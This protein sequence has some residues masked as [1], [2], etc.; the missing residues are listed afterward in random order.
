VTG[1]RRGQVR[2]AELGAGGQ[3][4]VLV[5]QTDALHT[6]PTVIVLPLVDTPQRVGFPLALYLP[7]AELGL[8]VETWIKVTQVAVLTADRLDHVVADLSAE[9]MAEVDDALREVLDLH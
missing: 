2:W 1:A 7:A 3:R 8:E 5:V 4:P 6:A 9:R